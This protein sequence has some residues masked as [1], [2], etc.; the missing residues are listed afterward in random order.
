M[1]LLFHFTIRQRVPLFGKDHI[2]QVELDNSCG[3]LILSDTDWIFVPTEIHSQITI[4]AQTCRFQNCRHGISMVVAKQWGMKK[5]MICN[6]C[7]VAKRK[8]LTP[9]SVVGLSTDK[10]IVNLYKY[11]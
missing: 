3:N 2:L 11:V 9:S 6:T 8:S 5:S 4:E 10:T 7:L 1:C